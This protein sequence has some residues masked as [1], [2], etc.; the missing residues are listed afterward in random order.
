MAVARRII[1]FEFVGFYEHI[2]T[3][4]A[5]AALLH[6]VSILLHYETS[7]WPPSMS[8]VAPVSAVLLMM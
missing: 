3:P 6:P 1:N 2:V 5:A 7:C 8:Y 4:T